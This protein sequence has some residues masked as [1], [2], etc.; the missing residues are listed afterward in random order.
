M[1]KSATTR[2][3][4]GGVQPLHAAKKETVNLNNLAE[5]VQYLNDAQKKEYL[6]RESAIHDLEQKLVVSLK[7]AREAEKGSPLFMVAWDEVEEIEAAI[8]HYRAKNAKLVGPKVDMEQVKKEIK[9]VRKEHPEWENRNVEEHPFVEGELPELYAKLGIEESDFGKKAEIYDVSDH[10]Q[11]IKARAELDAAMKRAMAAKK[12]SDEA[13]V[14]WDDVEELEASVSHL[15]DRLQTEVPSSISRLRTEIA[16]TVEE[17]AD[18]D[19]QKKACF[20]T[21]EELDAALSHAIK[22]KAPKVAENLEL[23]KSKIKKYEQDHQDVHQD[24]AFDEAKYN[25]AVIRLYQCQEEMRATSC[26]FDLEILDRIDETRELL[27]EA[28]ESAKKT[29]MGT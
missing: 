14:A 20:D 11:V 27:K 6:N 18:L 9:E 16:K 4:V 8:S 15:K 1:F 24:A 17:I 13:K 22:Q 23:I 26:K 12:G 19:R 3:M 28:L 10:P 25:A 2:H 7:E 5:G 21:L 29:K